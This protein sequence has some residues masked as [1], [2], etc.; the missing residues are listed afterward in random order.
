MPLENLEYAFNSEDFSSLGAIGS[1]TVA[2]INTNLGISELPN[3]IHT[4]YFRTQD[5]TGFASAP[6]GKS[7]YVYTKT[8]YDSVNMVITAIEYSFDSI[9]AFVPIVA[10]TPDTA[11]TIETNLDITRL[12][13]HGKHTVSMR[14]KDTR[15]FWGNVISDTLSVENETPAAHAGND[16]Y[17][18][19]QT[20]V[21]LDATAS[22]DLNN[23]GLSYHWTPPAGIVLSSNTDAKPTFIAPEIVSD[24]NLVFLLYVNDGLIDSPV[25]TLVIRVIRNQILIA[26]TIMEN[27]INQCVNAFSAIIIAGGDTAVVFENGSDLTLI[28]GELI[29]FL[30]GFHAQPGSYVLAYIENGAGFCDKVGNGS[31]LYQPPVEKSLAK[32]SSVIGL[33]AAGDKQVKV[34]PNPT[35]GRVVVELRNYQ[36]TSKMEITNLLGAILYQ[37]EIR[38][39]EPAQLDLSHLRKGLYLVHIKNQTDS[40]TEKLIIR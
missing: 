34:Y 1:D 18:G 26:D 35:N 10:N 6:F 27:G 21:T 17:A 28:A 22:T 15:N 23:D 2:E 24:T 25:D 5:S 11:V 38:E 19:D 13:G 3:G 29:R 8:I 39:N 16:R 7:F 14:A 30:P 20:Q 37:A 9:T 12:I 31:M 33:S 40:K 36:G 32:A 4:V